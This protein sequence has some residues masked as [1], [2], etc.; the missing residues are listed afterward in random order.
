MMYEFAPWKEEGWREPENRARKWD[1]EKERA[2]CVSFLFDI[3]FFQ[4]SWARNRDES[5]PCRDKGSEKSVHSILCR[6]LLSA[7]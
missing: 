1:F 3:A 5:T 2:V 6:V 4:K 7:R